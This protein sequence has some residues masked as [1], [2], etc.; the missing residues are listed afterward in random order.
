MKEYRCIDL[1][2]GAGGLSSGLSNRGFRIVGSIEK[3]K[4]FCKTHEHNFPTSVSLNADIREVPPERF[5]K[6]TKI[7]KNNVDLIMGGPPCQTFSTI[8][9]PKIK[10]LKNGDIQSDPRNYLYRSFF[11]YVKYY[12]PT[13]FLMENVPALRTKF[14]GRLF[15]NILDLARSLGYGP[16]SKVLNS[17]QYGVPQI[18]KRLFIVGT[19]KGIEYSFPEPDYYWFDDKAQTDLQ[20]ISDLADLPLKRAPTVG[21]AISDLPKIE[22]GNREDELPYSKNDKLT[23]YQKVLRNSNRLVK[24][25]ICRMSNDR[26]KKVFAHMKQGSKYMDLPKEI[27]DILPFREDIFFDRLK[28]LDESK[29]SWTV[30]AHIGMDGYMYIHPTENRTLS[31]RE[32]ARIQGFHDSFIFFGNMRE[33]YREVGNAVPPILAERL[34]DSI[35]VALEGVKT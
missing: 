8:G 18:R 20:N 2:A 25:N 11:Q 14:G 33:Q 27:R 3:E 7:E 9:V 23:D 1:F 10:S 32:A 35:A 31:V 24:N 6:G 5:E 22:D 4:A 34:G 21:H 28:R 29:P 17:V 16:Y 12:R 13:V 26:A 30:L 15:R 19:R